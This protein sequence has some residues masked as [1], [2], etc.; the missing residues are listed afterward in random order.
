[1]EISFPKN[2][3]KFCHTSEEILTQVRKCVPSGEKG[4]SPQGMDRKRN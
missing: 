3:D 2:E 4:I 1:M